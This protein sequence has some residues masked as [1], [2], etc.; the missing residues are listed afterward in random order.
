MGLA[1]SQQ[2]IEKMGSTIQV[3]STLGKGSHFWFDLD[4]S[5]AADWLHQAE[6][7][8]RKVIGYQG[9]RR[10]I[11][12]IDDYAE[13]RAVVMG[14]LQPLGFKVAEANDGQTGL[15]TAL[16]MRPDLI[17]T[18][19][20]M[21]TMSGLEMTR[22]LRQLADF[23]QTPIIASPATLS[24]VDM[25]DVIDAG[26]NSFFPKPIDFTGLLSELQ[27][28]LELQWIYEASEE[29]TSEAQVETFTDWVVPP[30]AELAAVYQAAQDGFMA[31]I[32][33]EANRLKQLEP[34][35]TAFA[36]KLLEL[37]QTFDDEALLELLTPHVER[38]TV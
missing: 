22:R 10:K 35:Y 17:I 13:N 32:Q 6:T 34:S 7:S 36:N 21:S 25:Q 19:V 8:Q 11:L 28:H 23:T 29:E 31:D 26:C 2:I 24:Q 16:R 27:R 20:M 30:A 18:D 3:E 12:V 14:M 38:L 1:I 5:I 15:D 37:S 33:Q 4:L 9:D